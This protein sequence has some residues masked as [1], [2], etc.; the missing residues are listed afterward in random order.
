MESTHDELLAIQ[1]E[2]RTRAR[3]N[4]FL[5][6]YNEYL[7]GLSKKE[8]LFAPSIGDLLDA[9]FFVQLLGRNESTVVVTNEQWVEHFRP[10]LEQFKI[11]HE[12]A[13]RRLLDKVIK[14]KTSG[15]VA[16][17]PETLHPSLPIHEL[18]K[19]I[20]VDG[21]VVFFRDT[22]SSNAYTYTVP[23]LLASNQMKG[24]RTFAEMESTSTRFL[25]ETCSLSSRM[26]RCAASLLCA[27]DM[28]GADMA[29]M[30]D[31]GCVFVCM[32]CPEE[33]RK[34][35]GWVDLVRRCPCSL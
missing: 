14:T 13:T 11:E 18:M 27:L 20:T 10:Q 12:D 24:K 34:R 7:D 32:L 23:E 9:S 17:P 31:M 28:K 15:L 30:V 19:N 5:V 22:D 3:C 6:H 35:R 21:A 2:R 16:M 26:A 4:E 1:H 25:F 8:A 29:D 33:K